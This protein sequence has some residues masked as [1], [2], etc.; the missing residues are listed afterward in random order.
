MAKTTVQIIYKQVSEGL[1][2][3]KCTKDSCYPSIT[4]TMD[5]YELRFKEYDNPKTLTFKLTRHL[6][7]SHFG[8][9]LQEK[10]KSLYPYQLEIL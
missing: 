6:C 9:N 10:A 7:C 2:G 1:I 8:E 4:P 3:L 5:M